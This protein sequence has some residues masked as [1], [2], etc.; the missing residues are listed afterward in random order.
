MTLPAIREAM[1]EYRRGD[2]LVLA[3]DMNLVAFAAALAARESGGSLGLLRWDGRGER[4]VALSAQLW[5]DEGA[6]RG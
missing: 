3:G 4:Y 5:E 2:Y 1:A 6:D